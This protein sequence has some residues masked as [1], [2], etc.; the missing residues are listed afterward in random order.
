MNIAKFDLYNAEWLDLV[1]DHRNKAYGAYDLRRHYS[2]NMVKAMGFTFAG[3][4]ILVAA[5][6]IFKPKPRPA[7]RII[8]VPIINIK[9]IKTEKLI[10]K[11]KVAPADVL[12]LLAPAVVTQWSHFSPPASTV[13]QQPRGAPR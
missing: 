9:H 3:V 4:A 8:D 6:I 11:P 7:M 12:K 2:R 5:S 10:E 13:A 1:F